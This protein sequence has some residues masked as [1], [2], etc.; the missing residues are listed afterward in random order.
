MARRVCRPLGLFSLSPL[1][2][3]SCCRA[4]PVSP[5][6]PGPR[7]YSHSAATAQHMHLRRLPWQGRY[8]CGLTPLAALPTTRARGLATSCAQL[9]EH[10]PYAAALDGSVTLARHCM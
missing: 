7:H 2:L 6:S 4:T 8:A 5:V 9:S 10:N 3:R 1:A